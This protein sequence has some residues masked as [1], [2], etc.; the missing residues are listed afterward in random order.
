M[1]DI[2]S[3]R[4]GCYPQGAHSKGSGAGKGKSKRQGKNRNSQAEGQDNRRTRRQAKLERDLT[5][6]CFHQQ[7]RA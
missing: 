6:R 4:G 5:S 1:H 7:D 2:K 3:S